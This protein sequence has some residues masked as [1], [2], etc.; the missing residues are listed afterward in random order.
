MQFIRHYLLAIQFFTR[1]PVTGRLAA[2]VG[3]SPEMLRAS[4]AH[5]PGVGV[6][7]GGLVA[8]LTAVL[9]LFLPQTSPL[10]PFLWCPNSSCT[11]VSVSEPY[12]RQPMAPLM[13]G[14]AAAMAL[15][16]FSSPNTS[17]AAEYS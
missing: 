2:W 5:F 15:S 8:G 7:V 6:L 17:S 9:L 10:S 12:T 13:R 3:Y 14:T 1:I 16:G 11:E 4:A